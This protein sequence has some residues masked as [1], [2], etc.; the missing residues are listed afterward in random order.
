[1]ARVT[2]GHSVF[3][4]ASD[5]FIVKTGTRQWMAPSP[6]LRTGF[7]WGEVALPTRCRHWLMWADWQLRSGC[8]PSAC[9]VQC[10]ELAI[11]RQTY[12]DGEAVRWSEGLNSNM[13]AAVALDKVAPP[14]GLGSPAKV[15][16]E[17]VPSRSRGKRGIWR[18]AGVPS[19]G[20]RRTADA[21][22]QANVRGRLEDLAGGPGARMRPGPVG[23]RDQGGSR[24]GRLPQLDFSPAASR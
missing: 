16:G 5:R 18:D 3:D 21:H 23:A 15:D 19:V 24:A 11:Q 2:S 7:A 13:L 9:R 22:R 14:R 20:E 17:T 8:G 12:A 6:R 1:M 4:Q 10:P